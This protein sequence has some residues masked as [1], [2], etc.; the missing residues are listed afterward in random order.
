MIA[1]RLRGV[2]WRF[3]SST[4][5]FI[6][7]FLYYLFHY[8]YLVFID[9]ERKTIEQSCRF[10]SDSRVSWLHYYQVVV[11][12]HVGEGRVGYS[13]GSRGRRLGQL[14]RAPREGGTKEG[15]AKIM[16][17]CMTKNVIDFMILNNQMF[18]INDITT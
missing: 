7:L 1:L 2:G 11:L 16:R 17:I 18:R 5:F 12:T 10:V 14:P 3:P 9:L 4:L 6:S 13:G 8:F 15:R